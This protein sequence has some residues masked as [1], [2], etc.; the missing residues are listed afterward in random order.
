MDLNPTWKDG[1]GEDE[2]NPTKPQKSTALLKKK[3][4]KL[5]PLATDTGSIIPT[6]M[7]YV[8]ENRGIYLHVKNNHILILFV[9]VFSLKFDPFWANISTFVAP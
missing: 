9:F 6:F 5:K 2:S 4:K 8:K 1:I 7:W 3:K